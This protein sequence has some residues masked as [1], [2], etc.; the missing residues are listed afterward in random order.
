MGGGPV[1]VGE[2]GQVRVREGVRYTYGRGVV[3]C[4]YRRV[5]VRYVQIN[6]SRFPIYKSFGALFE[7]FYQWNG[8][9]G[10]RKGGGPV[11]VREGGGTVRGIFYVKNW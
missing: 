10:T 5:G 11:R 6:T 8:G 4:A 9:S 2:G 3:R 1:R 7:N